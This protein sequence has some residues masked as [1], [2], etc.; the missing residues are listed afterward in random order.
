MN[1]GHHYSPAS[2]SPHTVGDQQECAV[3]QGASL[4]SL[5]NSH[6]LSM[7]LTPFPRMLKTP[8]DPTAKG[9]TVWW[10]L[11]TCTGPWPR[12]VLASTQA[13][14]HL[15]PSPNPKLTSCASYSC[16]CQDCPSSHCTE[17]SL[18]AAQG[19]ASSP[20]AHHCKFSLLN[21]QQ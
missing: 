15:G 6:C 2:P 4:L 14:C 21:Q 9:C 1:T 12:S 19:Q 16:Y 3:K 13:V 17:R 20:N 10:K 8:Y 7:S 11:K 5:R 18:E